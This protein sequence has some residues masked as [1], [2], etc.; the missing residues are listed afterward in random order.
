MTDIKQIE[1]NPAVVAEYQRRAKKIRLGASGD[2]IKAIWNGIGD[3]SGMH[4]D[5]RWKKGDY[6]NAFHAA[7]R[8]L[9]GHSAQDCATI[10][11]F[12]CRKLIST[13]HS[14]FEKEELA[15]IRDECALIM[16]CPYSHSIYRPS[17]R[18]R[19]AGA[20]ADAFFVSMVNALNFL[21][22]DISLEKALTSKTEPASSTYGSRD[23]HPYSKSVSLSGQ[24]YRIATE[25]RHGNK[26]IF[27]LIEEAILGDN[28]EIQ[29]SHSILSGI[30]KSDDQQAIEFLG[31]LLLAAKGQE[32]LRQAILETCDS[33]TLSSHTYF[34]RMI[35]E[36]DLCRFSSVIRAFDTWSG[37]AYGDQK[38]KVAE[39]CMSLALKY[40]SDEHAASEGLDAN[41]ATEVY[42]ALWSICCRDL[43][44]A[45][46][47][48]RRLLDS[49]EKYKRLVGWY[50]ITH[51][52]D[53][54]FRHHMAI[55]Y[56]GVRDPE[57]LAWI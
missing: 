18:S 42:L 49:P 52:N 40:L 30:V 55:R 3:T 43:Y 38:Q 7:Y 10:D 47:S 46:D 57:E 48:A 27:A 22:Y 26:K 51:T 2:L 37:L 45:T 13:L 8:E 34:I 29:I 44:S 56:L 12:F 23:T 36:N 50:F 9:C 31:K 32:G 28:S 15:R 54:F 25:L 19:R 17:Y 5:Y 24:D 39:K 4:M 33:G 41:D 1:W 53:S 20:Y 6:Q 16:E 35:L 11:D 21:C 14:F